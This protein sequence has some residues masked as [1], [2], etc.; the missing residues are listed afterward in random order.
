MV[1]LLYLPFDNSENLETSIVYH[2]IPVTN[3][4]AQRK[5]G[6]QISSLATGDPPMVFFSHEESVWKHLWWYQFLPTVWLVNRERG[7]AGQGP[8]LQCNP[9]TPTKKPWSEVESSP[10]S[11]NPAACCDVAELLEPSYLALGLPISIV[12]P[13]ESL[14]GTCWRPK[15]TTFLGQ[16]AFTYTN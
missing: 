7:R 4:F 1:H 15:E 6:T 9:L 12:D 10:Q 2:L 13:T 16:P 3:G 5:M 11:A 14:V 8:T